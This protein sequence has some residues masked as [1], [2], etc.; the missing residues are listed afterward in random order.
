M[1]SEQR[2]YLS[3]KLLPEL[4]GEEEGELNGDHEGE[5]KGEE[6]GELKGEQEGELKGEQEGELKYDF[7]NVKVKLEIF[8]ICYIQDF[9]A[10]AHNST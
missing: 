4:K 3:W 6:E 5:L 8:T 9:N 1:R 7:L 10:F 2:K